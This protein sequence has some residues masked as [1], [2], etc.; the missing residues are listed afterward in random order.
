MVVVEEEE[1]E[2]EEKEEE[3][4]VLLLTRS[5]SVGVTVGGA[6]NAVRSEGL[7][8]LWWLFNREEKFVFDCITSCE[9]D[10]CEGDDTCGVSC[11]LLWEPLCL[12]VS[13]EDK[14]PGLRPVEL[15]CAGGKPLDLVSELS[16]DV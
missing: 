5:D 2:E 15:P 10:G 8:A 3:G 7:D 9:R 13:N 1:E 12:A 6:L 11:R 16:R 4:C 14:D